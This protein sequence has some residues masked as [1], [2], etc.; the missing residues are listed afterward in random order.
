MTRAEQAATIDP[1]AGASREA[2]GGDLGARLRELRR[3]RG[4]SLAEVAEGT[5]ISAS[6][7]STVEKGKSDITVSRLMPANAVG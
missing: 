3:S 7:L 1:G 5:G 2:V 4:V 6:F